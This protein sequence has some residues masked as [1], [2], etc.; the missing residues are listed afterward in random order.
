ML[1]EKDMGLIR[2][3]YKQAMKADQLIYDF[4]KVLNEI[5]RVLRPGG[6][7]IAPTLWS[8]KG[9][10]KAASGQACLDDPRHGGTETL[11]QRSGQGREM[12][13][14]HSGLRG[15]LRRAGGHHGADPERMSGGIVHGAQGFGASEAVHE[16]AVPGQSHLQ[17]LDKEIYR[18]GRSL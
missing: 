12:V 10:W 18:F 8:M 14:R 4:I 3:I 7:L 16:Q 5:K 1:D 2:A 13:H 15:D 6:L 11:H 17:D 9:R